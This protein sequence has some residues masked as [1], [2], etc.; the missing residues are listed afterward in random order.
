[1][2]ELITEPAHIRDDS[3]QSCIDPSCTDQSYVFNEI[4]VLPSL[5]PHSKHNIIDGSLHFHNPSSPP[6][7]RKVWDY[8]TA[9]IDLIRNDLL[10][11]D[12]NSMFFGLNND[13][14]S[15]VFTDTL[16]SIFSGY[17]SNKMITCNDKDA[18]G[19]SQWLNLQCTAILEL[20][21]NGLRVGVNLMITTKSVKSNIQLIKLF[22]KLSAHILESWRKNY[23]I[24]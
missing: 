12:W 10:N 7:K 9:K 8:K 1:M 23:L 18:R 6:Y 16:L 21:E 5:N 3:S 20:I 17:I 14:M 2:E 11:T 15:L 22:V 19:L 4:D 24:L 13:E